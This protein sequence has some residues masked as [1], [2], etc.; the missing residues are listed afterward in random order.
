MGAMARWMD[1]LALALEMRARVRDGARAPTR[2]P[3]GALVPTARPPDPAAFG[4]PQRDGT[5][6]RLASRAAGGA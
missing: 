3:R 5:R 1:G 4:A 6:R 2:R